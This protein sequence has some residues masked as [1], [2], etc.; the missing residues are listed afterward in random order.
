MG[1]AES[2]DAAQALARAD[3]ILVASGAGLSADSGL[4]TYEGLRDQG[5]DYDTLCRAELLYDKPAL[6]Q[7]FWMS[8]LLKYRSTE[9]H[10]GFRVLETLLR[11][12]ADRG[13]VYLYT[14]N[15]DGHLRH[16]VLRSYI[17]GIFWIIFGILRSS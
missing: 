11:D 12:R 14:S 3:W 7:S 6:F 15:V 8:S 16:W 1:D 13:R 2:I 10:E 5:V 4:E 9:P 17:F